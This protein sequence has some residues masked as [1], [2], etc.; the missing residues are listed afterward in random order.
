MTQLVFLGAGKMATAIAA[1]LLEQR[2]FTAAGLLA[3]DK[4]EAARVAFTAATGV[5]C[6]ADNA[7][8]VAGAEAVLLAIKPQDAPTALPPLADL[9][10]GKLLISIAA[11]L[12]L[13]KLAG[14]ARTER[15]IRVM[16]NT[17]DMVR[18]GAA[19]YACA[20]GA[21][22]ADRALCQRIF[23]AVGIACEMPE[24]QLDAVTGVSGSGP[25]YVFEFV[26]AMVEGA[27]RAGLPADAAL[28]LVV[29]TVAGAAEMLRQK[30]GTPD[31]LRQA[32]TSKGGTTAAGLQVLADAHFRDLMATVIQRATERSRELGRG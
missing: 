26:Q 11:G 13:A 12:S 31:E 8:A 15:V 29:Q 14:W 17:P 5:R 19:V 1:G 4:I 7:A 21:T 6:V 9:L 3:A 24:A 16:P 30:R 28:D 25:A 20:P 32:V 27:V 10:A 18:M 22:A 23:S 2:V